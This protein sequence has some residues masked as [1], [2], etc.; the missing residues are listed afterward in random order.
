[1]PHD[2]LQKR[3]TIVRKRV[4]CN[5]MPTRLTPSIDYVCLTTIRL[6]H[7]VA[8]FALSLSKN[9]QNESMINTVLKCQS[10]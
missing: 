7:D 4:E 5:N 8:L 6:C 1:M 3:E 10:E 2:T 9:I